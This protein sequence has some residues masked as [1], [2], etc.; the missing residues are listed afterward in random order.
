MQ[1]SASTTVSSAK[2][3][4]AAQVQAWLIAI[5]GQSDGAAS[6]VAS[7]SVGAGVGRR[8]HTCAGGL[9]YRPSSGYRQLQYRRPSVYR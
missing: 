3:V 2:A 5:I 1:Y 4:T 9:G 7:A 8:V 6:G